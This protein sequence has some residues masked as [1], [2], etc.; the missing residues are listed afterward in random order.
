M[1][2]I[3]LQAFASQQQRESWKEELAEAISSP[4]ELL[5]ILELEHMLSEFV[6]NDST[7]R[8]RVPRAYVAKMQKG[9]PEDPLLLQVLPTLK[10]KNLSG[11][12]DPVGDLNALLSPGLLHKYHGRA[13]LISTGACAIHCRYCFRRHFP[14]SENSGQTSN[15]QSALDYLRAHPEIHEVILS[16]GDP[17][18]LDDTKLETLC[19]E[20][21]TIGHIKW[22][23]L[24]TR[25]PVVL[26]CRINHSLLQWMKKSRFR[27]TV[28]IHAN[29]AQE[30][31]F[32]EKQAL[33]LLAEIGVT[34]LNQS[35]LLNGI[36]DSTSDLVDLSTRLHDLGVVPY[37][38]HLLDKVQGAI[39][40]EVDHKK[41]CEIVANM[42]AQLPGF[43]V[44]R[45]VREESGATSKTA[46]SCI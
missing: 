11:S 35:V 41:A 23:R 37:Y 7:F 9:D 16:G 31:G 10:E 32:S 42:R 2:P 38:L 40:F 18:I 44:P 5:R 25:L 45:L 6:D 21:E 4:A 15:W 12:K 34:L 39:H 36:N 14:Y 46:I 24:H 22:L 43:L 8:L 33:Q 19:S 1:P 17:L 20:L 3:S 27:I 13:L 29:H 26:P 28:V 30:L